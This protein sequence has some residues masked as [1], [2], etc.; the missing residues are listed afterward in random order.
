[1]R[2]EVLAHDRQAHASRV[3][4]A[5]VVAQGEESGAGFGVLDS[6]VEPVGGQILGGE[7][8]LPPVWAGV[9]FPSAGSGRTLGVLVAAAAF[10]ALPARM[11]LQGSRGRIRQARTPPPTHRVRA[12]PRGRRSRHSIRVR[13]ESSPQVGALIC[14]AVITNGGECGGSST[15]WTGKS[16]VFPGPARRTA[17]SWLLRICPIVRTAMKM[18]LQ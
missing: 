4:T 6:P 1:M 17:E 9:R 11:R 16:V 7:Q 5:Q 18:V 10:G 13:D 8:V 3:E 15:N 12:R 2:G 14:G